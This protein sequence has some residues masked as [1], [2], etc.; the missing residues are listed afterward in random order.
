M[1]K[2]EKFNINSFI[3]SFLNYHHEINNLI[4]DNIGIFYDLAK[5]VNRETNQKEMISEIDWNKVTRKTFLE[6]IQLI[7]SFHQNI[8]IN[9]KI[10]DII[11][12]GT[13]NILT[14]DLD[15]AI[16]NESSELLEGHNCYQSGHKSIDIYNNGLIT[17]SV[18][19]VHEISHYRNQTDNGRRQ[20]NHLLT[21]AV[22]HTME[23]I[24]L[25]YLEK[26]GCEYEA[27]HI[28]SI[29]LNTFHFISY[30]AYILTKMY[31]LYQQLGDTSKE[32][33]KYYY[34]QDEDY[35]EIKDRF[36]KTIEKNQDALFDAIW[37]TLSGALSIYMYDR[38][39][40]ENNFIYKIEEL[41]SAI[42]NDKS[43]AECLKIINITG[44]NKESK[45]KIKSAFSDYKSLLGNY[46]KVSKK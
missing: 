38:Y 12:D 41:N 15:E 10:D 18:I 36:I 3:D 44:Y 23:L 20:T 42:T 45:D 26:I 46:Q 40:K 43:I 1:E 24:Y 30:R 22:A 17:D 19:W 14:N 25:D 27:Y 5:L 8:G 33:Y 7:D 4:V 34:G 32:S 2:N 37:Y 9:F 39:R 6:N 35:D 11:K 29:L 16:N 31:L 13:I 28:R 21:E